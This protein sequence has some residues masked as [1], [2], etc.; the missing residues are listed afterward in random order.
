MKHL[1]TT[2]STAILIAAFAQPVSATII[3]DTY[4]G[5]P[6]TTAS[7]SWGDRIGNHT[8]SGGGYT[9]EVHNMDVTLTGTILNVQINTNYAGHAGLWGTGYGDLFL[10]SAWAPDP[11]GTSTNN[12][13]TD[14]YTNG[15][16][17]TYGL[18]IDG[19]RFDASSAGGNVSLFELNGSNAQ[20]AILS[21]SLTSGGFRNGQEVAVNTSSGTTVDTGV[22]GTWGISA[23]DAD[24]FISF[25]I[26]LAGTTLLDGGEIALHWGMTCGNDTI[27]GAYSV[28]EPAILALLA[29]G[30]IGI[31][32]STRKAS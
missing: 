1:N 32:I 23:L 27:E 16:N 28:P 14:R 8:T 30:L 22:S 20:D 25:S 19:D 12:Y 3:D 11:D 15:T 31:G 17:W 4:W 5:H 21:D 2:L 7:A 29:I 24:D 9:F 13:N 6:G 26:N 18:S 10:S